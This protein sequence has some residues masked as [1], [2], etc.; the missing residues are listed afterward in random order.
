MA[1]RWAVASGNWSNTATWNGGTLPTAA[2]DVYADGKTVTIDQDVTV[3]TLRRDV[4]SGGVAGGSFECSTTRTINASIIPYYDNV[5]IPVLS[6]TVS[7]GQTVTLNGTVNTAWSGAAGGWSYRA[8]THSGTGTLTIN[9]NVFPGAHTANAQGSTIGILVSSTGTLNINGSVN[10][11]NV[12][13]FNNAYPAISLSAAGHTL[14]ITGNVTGKSSVVQTAVGTI[15]IVGDIVAGNLWTTVA[16]SVIG[17]CTIV[18]SVTG[19]SNSALSGGAVTCSGTGTCSITGFLYAQAGQ[20]IAGAGTFTVTGPF[21]SSATG[22]QPLLATGPV[23]LSPVLNNE[24]RF[25]H[26]TSGTASLWS[27]DVN[28]G[29]PAAANV[30]SGITYGVGGALTGTLVVPPANSVAAG[31]PV[32]NTTGTAAVRLEDI[33]AVTGAQIAA[34]LTR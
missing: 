28:G 4:R 24:F 23:L 27:T 18:G 10:G 21:I 15:N 13:N 2:D 33:A 12:A 11:A 29:Q 19:T 25:K 32:D 8:I 20:A 1:V 9:G 26:V 31:V 30:R 17:V 7:L 3:L 16:V 22:V 34:A 14:N 6:V 5:N